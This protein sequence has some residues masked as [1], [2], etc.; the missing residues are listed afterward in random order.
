MRAA[1]PSASR[2][3]L[4]QGRG[5]RQRLTPPR[6]LLDQL[7]SFL[8][9]GASSGGAAAKREAAKATL[10]EAIAPLKRGLLATPEDAEAVE[11]AAQAL[12]RL[13]PT[14]KALSSP[15]INGQWELLYTTSASIL[16]AK[17]PAFLRPSGP[18]FQLIDA[19]N[20]RARNRESAPLWNT[21]SADLRPMSPS[22][23]AVQ[24]DE[25]GLFGGA[26]KVKAPPS[27]KGEL[28]TTFLDEEIRVSRGDKGNLFVL[29][30]VDR[31]ARP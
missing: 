5:A 24:F 4:S 15:L 20:L 14:P 13:N 8:S 31:D 30:M 3:A 18:I 23:V 25:F 17:K 11:A 7:Q 12:E 16:G 2:A 26:I 27:A 21:V 9:G 22:K 29:R 28:D 6:A 19:P 10:L 1:T